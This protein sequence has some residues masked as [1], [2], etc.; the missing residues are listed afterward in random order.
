M[1]RLNQ[2]Q[3]YPEPLPDQTWF[4]PHV[5]YT[6]ASYIPQDTKVET[7]FDWLYEDTASCTYVNYEQISRNLGRYCSQYWN[8]YIKP[9]EGAC[10]IDGDYTVTWSA[11]C[12]YDKP[13]CTFN[14]DADGNT[15][16]TVAATFT[17]HSTNMCPELVHEVDIYGV[18]CPTGRYDYA[19]CSDTNS[20]VSGRPNYWLNEDITTYFQDDQVHFFIQTYTDD[21]KIIYTEILEIWVEQDFSDPA[22]PVDD[23]VTP[24]DQNY[25]GLVK[26]WDSSY[27]DNSHTFTSSLTGISETVPGVI[28]DIKDSNDF[29]DY[30]P[31]VGHGKDDTDYGVY[32]G[33]RV[34]V[35]SR[36]FPRTSDRWLDATFRVK[37]LVYYEGW[38]NSKPDDR[39]NLQEEVGDYERNGKQSMWMTQSIQVKREVPRFVPCFADHETKAWTLKMSLTPEQLTHMHGDIDHYMRREMRTLMQDNSIEWVGYTSDAE[40][41]NSI[42]AVYRGDASKWDELVE[43]FTVGDFKLGPMFFDLKVSDIYCLDATPE[44]GLMPLTECA[45]GMPCTFLPG[46][47]TLENYY[48][49][50][51]GNMIPVEDDNESSVI[52]LSTMMAFVWALLF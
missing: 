43:K 36:I 50:G 49:Q 29:A 5:A 2:T 15:I 48:G 16:N 30:F 34:R 14:T 7:T 28:E 40:N 17:V 19:L 38:G 18:I 27:S 26:L 44:V 46:Q 6:P 8:M 13:I 47:V 20:E 37:L 9:L 31:T 35:D 41:E 1:E 24:I 45:S 3:Y 22:W 21:S 42:T 11:R 52:I 10:Y 33:Y 39:R 4:P 32:A 12:F 51:T 25:N 23:T